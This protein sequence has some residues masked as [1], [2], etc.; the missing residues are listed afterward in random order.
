MPS[1]ISYAKKKKYFRGQCQIQ[2]LKWF[3]LTRPFTHLQQHLQQTKKSPKKKQRA[4]T[5][6]GRYRQSPYPILLFPFELNVCTFQKWEKRN[7]K[8]TLGQSETHLCSLPRIQQ[9]NPVQQLMYFVV[10]KE[11]HQKID[12]LQ[13]DVNH[14]KEKQALTQHFFQTS[15]AA[16]PASSNVFT[17]P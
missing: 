9:R 17:K 6:P 10:V 13:A 3:C 11:L 2:F 16:V 15:A 14:V 12:A 1:C 8:Q 7:W 5:Q 4:R